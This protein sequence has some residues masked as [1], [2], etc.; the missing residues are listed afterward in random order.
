LV[1]RLLAPYWEEY[2]SL[3]IDA[4]ARSAARVTIVRSPDGGSVGPSPLWHVRQ[5]LSDPDENL[6]HAL[7]FAVDVDASR[8]SNRLVMTWLGLSNGA[9][10][11]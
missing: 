5:A 8:S 11:S 9:G 1:E 4:D 2:T 10:E 3:A 7:E 6:D